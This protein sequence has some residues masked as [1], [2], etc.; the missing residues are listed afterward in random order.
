[1]PPVSILNPTREADVE[2]GEQTGVMTADSQLEANGIGDHGAQPRSTKRRCTWLSRSASRWNNDD[3]GRPKTARESTTS[4]IPLPRLLHQF[5]NHPMLTITEEE[6]PAI[7]SRKSSLKSNPPSVSEQKPVER[8][9]ILP[10][11]PPLAESP[12]A[13]SD[14][15]AEAESLK[16]DATTAVS[17]DADSLPPTLNL[18][19]SPRRK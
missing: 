1:M 16:Q 17:I 5:H 11:K 8:P 10:E 2:G 12:P 3:D 18:D 6:G 9:T 19:E 13:E 4:C 14:P 7:I 15:V